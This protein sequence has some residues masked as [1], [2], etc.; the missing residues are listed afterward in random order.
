M[1]HQRLL[2]ALAVFLTLSTPFGV[3]AQ[4]TT[5]I[6]G[7]GELHYNE[8]D[9]SSAGQL[10]FHRFVLYLGHDFND[11]ISFRSEVELEHTKIEAGEE[12]GGEL[13]LEQAFLEYRISRGFGLRGGILLAPVG[14]INLF[15]EP[16]TFHGVER[17]SVDRV[18]I[19]TTWRES[20]IGVFGSPL[21]D[22]GYQLYVVAG[23]DAAGFSGANG[24]RGGRQS[25]FE[26]N[27]ANPSLTGRV[28]YM[29]G[30]GLQLGG[31]FFAGS[32][33]GDNDSI[34][35]AMVTLWSADIRYTIAGA[36]LKAVGAIGSIG[37]ADLINKQFGANVAD[38]LYGFYIEGAY[39]ILPLLCPDSEQSVTLFGRFERYN[40]QASTTGFSPLK[41]Y[42]RTDIVVGA[43]YHPVYNA[44]VKA[45]Y[46]FLR[47][48]LDSGPHSNTGQLNIGIGYAF[49]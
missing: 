28:D 26:S 8:P 30:T 45:D 36:S 37:D 46:T 5:T 14:L 15:H 17:P 9:G 13:A 18:I 42:D 4:G 22:F 2:T 7:Y 1:T 16:P 43:S 20:G 10:D 3:F 27:P 40:T 31:S 39:N 24:L 32:A 25:G 49:N 19:P 23:L 47:N 6:G 29:P 12:E 33:A 21:E 48:A 35:T 11:Q 38:E 44:V 41:Q 34:G